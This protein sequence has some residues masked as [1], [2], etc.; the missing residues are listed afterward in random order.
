MPLVRSSSTRPLGWISVLDPFYEA[1][2]NVIES[3]T[4][5]YDDFELVQ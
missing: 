3:V 4:L 5:T 2:S 1:D